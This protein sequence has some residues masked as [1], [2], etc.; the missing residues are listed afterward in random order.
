MASKS[1]GVVPSFGGVVDAN[2]AVAL[3]DTVHHW[4]AT[5]VNRRDG[6][7]GMSVT[8]THAGFRVNAQRRTFVDAV[9][10]AMERLAAKDRPK[11]RL[12]R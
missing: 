3:L 2:Q 5:R 4:R 9:N 8:I 1:G 10:A 11:M 6:V 12:A 7:P